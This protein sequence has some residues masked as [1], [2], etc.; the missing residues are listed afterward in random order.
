MQRDCD[1]VSTSWALTF[2]VVVL[3]LQKE[4]R[5]DILKIVSLMRIDR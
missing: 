1:S 3:N 4:D 2:F 5:I